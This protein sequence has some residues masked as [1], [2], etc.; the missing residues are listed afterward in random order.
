MKLILGITVSLLLC[1]DR[2]KT[3][4]SHRD[5]N[6]SR[7]ICRKQQHREDF[8]HIGTREMEMIKL[9]LA[10]LPCLEANWSSRS[11][12][13]HSYNHRSHKS[14]SCCHWS[15]YV[16]HLMMSHCSTRMMYRFRYSNYS[17][18]DSRASIP[19]S[20]RH[21]CQMARQCSSSHHLFLLG[22]HCLARYPC[23]QHMILSWNISNL[24]LL[25][26]TPIYDHPSRLK[27]E[28]YLCYVSEWFSHQQIKVI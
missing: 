13:R 14:V 21:S 22:A 9:N 5:R 20:R 6:F 24:L 2:L 11:E 23:Y 12:R 16:R 25:P 26:H 10:L 17:Q 19:P 8:G 28:H 3:H 1:F 15:Q 7:S 18:S 27:F 4:R